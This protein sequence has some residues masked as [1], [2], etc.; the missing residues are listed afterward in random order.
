MN[1]QRIEV[2]CYSGRIY[3]DRPASFLW[4]DKQYEVKEIEKEW[5]EPGE[6][7]FR[8]RTKDEKRFELCYHEGNDLWSIAEII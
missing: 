6:K 1:N 3:A 4:Q 7:H 2:T 5:Q 8:V